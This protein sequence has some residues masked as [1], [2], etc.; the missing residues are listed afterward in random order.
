MATITAVRAVIADIVSNFDKI[1]KR[2]ELFKTANPGWDLTETMKLVNAEKGMLEDLKKCI[3]E[4][5]GEWPIE[6]LSSLKLFDRELAGG[7]I[8]CPFSDPSFLNVR[9]MD[10]NRSTPCISSRESIPAGDFQGLC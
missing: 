4:H 2:V 5:A 6:V 1:E 9:Q 3:D 10:T 8:I 7:K